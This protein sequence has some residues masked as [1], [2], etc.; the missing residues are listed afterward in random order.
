[1]N[2]WP[3]DQTPSL[4]PPTE[5]TQIMYTPATGARNPLRPLLQ[6]THDSV[7]MAL[8]PC[9][10]QAACRLA[11]ALH[12]YDASL[13]VYAPNE[14][15]RE[16]W[17]ATRKNPVTWHAHL[18]WDHSGRSH[19]LSSLQGNS[20]TRHP[21]APASPFSP[22]H[23]LPHTHHYGTESDTSAAAVQQQKPVSRLKNATKRPP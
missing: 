22:I 17:A 6:Y 23:S 4:L 19:Q 1:M 5:S 2:R 16:P 18:P 12:A 11:T 7:C 14:C 20:N 9:N 15:H 10:L 8:Q 3:S 13:H 21:G